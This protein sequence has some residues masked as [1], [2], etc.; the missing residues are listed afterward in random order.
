MASAHALRLCPEL[1]ILK[2]D[3]DKY[4]R[5]SGDIRDIFARFT[6]LIEPLSLDEAYLDVTE[7]ERFENSAT[8]IARAIREQVRKDIGITVSAGV[9][10]NKFLAKIASDWDKPD[11]LFVIP[12]HSVEDFV[13]ELP[14]KKISGVGRVTA[15]KLSAL[16]I[17]TCA[18][19]QQHSVVDLTQRFGSFGE[20][21][22]QLARGIDD[23]RVQ[24]SRRRKSVSVEKTYAEDL[25]SLD[26][27]RNELPSL[28]EKLR[29]RLE[30]LDSQYL[31][32]AL[33]A[34][35]RYRDFS[36]STCEAGGGKLDE[37]AYGELLETLWQRRQLP[38]RLLGIGVRLRDTDMPL[39]PDLF[40]EERDAA[41]ISYRSRQL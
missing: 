3:F 38:A 5:I 18:Q 25:I 9:A 23:R 8:R 32:Q 4:R 14:V 34:K 24:T 36:L 31:I 2:P 35:V 6:D 40:P 16:G 11:G 7:S 29:E 30:R 33:V 26:S 19:L 1:V 22:H 39:Q 41:L 12:P 17:E 15:E 10:P 28:M 21:L 37:S 27:W 13:R 20:K